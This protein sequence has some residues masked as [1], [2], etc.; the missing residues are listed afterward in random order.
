MYKS[1]C[2]NFFIKINFTKII[3]ENSEI[4]NMSGYQE[5]FLGHFIFLFL[6]KALRS[7]ALPKIHQENFK[8]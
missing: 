2:R 3:A 8:I 7:F 5:I 6:M 4:A 1:S